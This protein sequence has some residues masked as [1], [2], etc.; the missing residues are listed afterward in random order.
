M[1]AAHALIDWSPLL[2]LLG[3]AAVIALLP[4]SWWWLRQRGAPLPRKLAALT[5]LILF[6]TVDLIA[7]GAFT[8]LTDSGLG[9]PDWPGCYGELTPWGAKTEISAAQA[10]QPTGPVTHG[11]AWIEMLHRYLAMAVGALILV[12]AAMAWR[13]RAQLPHS[14]WWATATLLW[15]LVQGAFGKYTVTLKLYP[16]VVTLHLLGAQVLLV[17]L[18]LQHESFRARPLAVARQRLAPAWVAVVLALVLVQIALGGWVST[19]YAV[20]AC[21]GFPTCNGQWWPQ[22]DAAHGFTLL[23][24]LGQTGQAVRC[25]SMPWW[26]STWRTAVCG[27][28]GAGPG[29]AGGGA[30]PQRRCHRPALCAGAGRPAAVAAGQ[31]AVERGAGLAHR[32]S[33]GPQRRCGRP[34][35]G[36]D[37]AVGAATAGAG[38]D[39]LGTGGRPPARW[40]WSSWRPPAAGLLESAVLPMTASVL[41]STPAASRVRQYLALTKPRVVQLIV[42]CA[43]IGM[44]L[45]EP[46]WPSLQLALPATIGIWL[47]ASAAAAF[48]CLVEQAIDSKMAR[49]AWRPTAK[50]ELSTAQALLF[51][52]VLCSLG[53]ALLYWWV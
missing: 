31:R 15:V 52:A 20:L 48:N 32:R 40:R 17:L 4:L 8:R 36:A 5:A 38:R 47:V 35:G 19:N 22:M 34:G 14:P 46:G 41:P 28:G 49:T 24:H 16:A 42:F 7:V 39:G 12:A 45:A 23:R 51:S 33:A 43:V 6:L 44:L 50:G 10:A 2:R 27:G 53:S 29:G 1:E 18:V 13:A 37:L 25:R 26:P 11:K 3:L 9:C 21:Q 30:A